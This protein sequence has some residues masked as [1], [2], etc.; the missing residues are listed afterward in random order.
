MSEGKDWFTIAKTYKID[1]PALVVY[2]ERVKENINRL[3]G[4][5][6]DRARLRPHVKTH[7]CREAALLMMEAGIHKFKC[8]TIAEAEMLGQ[9]KATDVLLAYQPVGPML[10]RFIGLVKK[11]PVTVF[12][13]I[14]DNFFCASQIAKLALYCNEEIAVYVDLNPGMNRTG[15]RPGKE[16]LQL[17]EACSRL[18]GLRVAGLHVYDGHIRN[19][20]IEARMT[21]C[22]AAFAPVQEM[23]TALRQKGFAA[24]KII[25]GGTP[26]FPFYAAMQDI[27]CS[28]GTF[29]FWDKGYQCSIPE[30]HFLPAAL[31]VTRIISQP[32]EHLL[33]LDLGYKAIASENELKNRVH[34]LNAPGVSVV[35]HSE[36]HMVIDAG[37]SHPWKIGD[38]LYGLP[39]HICPT[40]ALY[41]FALPVSHNVISGSWKIIARDRQLPA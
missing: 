37:K 1:T 3:I 15:I 8:A 24:P 17:Y 33:C 22:R 38:L 26:T 31:V 27:E 10:R 23:V 5:I 39:V 34:F 12:S 30:Q 6:D 11:Y 9:C 20:D 25:A 32:A 29:V 4:M 41:P 21:A 18:E 7:K 13:C 36:E 40:V 2:P 14:V 19:R 16:A 28:P 35:S